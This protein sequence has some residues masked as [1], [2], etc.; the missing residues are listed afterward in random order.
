MKSITVDH[1]VWVKLLDEHKG[2]ARRQSAEVPKM[3]LD[4]CLQKDITIYMSTR[5]WNWDAVMMSSQADHER[6]AELVSEYRVQETP[7][8]FRLGDSPA[9]DS[10]FG[11]RGSIFG[12]KDLLLDHPSECPKTQAFIKTFGPDPIEINPQNTGNKL[13]NWIGDYDSLKGHYLAGHDIF[14]TLDTNPPCFAQKTRECAAEELGLLI[15]SPSETL[16]F[17]KDLP[18]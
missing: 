8:G 10:I 17:L 18:S 11:H 12:G 15:K 6:L 7:T 4:Y 14:V 16:A 5:V 13:P 1:C 2:E 3:L 9:G